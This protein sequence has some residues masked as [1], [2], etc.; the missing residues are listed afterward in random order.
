[1]FASGFSSPIFRRQLV[2]LLTFVLT[3]CHHHKKF[4]LAC[5]VRALPPT[6]V[7]HG[8]RGARWVLLCHRT[9]VTPIGDTG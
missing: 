8:V 7:V 4:A 9:P 2:S 3:S 5:K 6:G 1:M